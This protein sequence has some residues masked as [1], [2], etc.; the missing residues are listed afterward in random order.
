MTN[1]DAVARRKVLFAGGIGNIIEWYD[2]GLYGFLATT[3]ATLFF[4]KEQSG[5]ALLY[6][7]AIFAVGFVPRPLGAIV[8][9]HIGDRVGRRPAVLFAVILMS[10]GTVAIG[11]LPGYSEIGIAAPIL[12]LVCRLVQGFSAGGEY[13]GATIF[14]VEHA[15]VAKRGRY[16]SVS[17]ITSV[18][19]YALGALVTMI[20]TSSTTHEQLLSWGWRVPFL[21]AVPL[22]LTGL[23]L[24]LRVQESPVFAELGDEGDLES[25]PVVQAMKTAKKPIL[26]ALGYTMTNALAFYLLCTFMTPYLTTVADFSNTQALVV[27]VVAL[28][29]AAVGLVIAGRFIDVF[30][31]KR[32]AVIAALCLTVW[33]IPAFVLLRDSSPVVACV[34][35]AVFACFYSGTA[36][37][38]ALAVVE[39]FPAHVRASGS[40]LAYTLAYTLF[41][42]TAPYVST[43][44]VD[45]DLVLA[46]GY[47]LAV[48]ALISAAVAAIGIGNQPRANHAPGLATA[49][50]HSPQQ[51]NA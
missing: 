10:A 24:R 22:A 33:A 6:T 50:G 26:I 9:G 17:P 51:A 23:Y 34:V 37:T 38:T 18:L 35:A 3:M 5:A 45:R 44:F 48:M 21:T 14:V 43:W 32:I 36:A 7:F 25:A 28:S 11:V 20:V 12:L 15:P 4:P 47:Y 31:R 8:F 16:A 1:Q 49:P 29:V 46:P 41:G 30:G 27:Q 19:G 42:G 39:L 40:G 13:T 2:I